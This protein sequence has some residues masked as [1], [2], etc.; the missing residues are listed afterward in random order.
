LRFNPVSLGGACDIFITSVVIKISLPGGI[1]MRKLTTSCRVVLG[2]IF[3]LFSTSYYLHF[4]PI[5]EHPEAAKNFTSAMAATGY[6]YPLLK[7]TEFVCGLALLTGV[8]VP[9]G[10]TLLAPILINIALFHLVL[11]PGGLGFTA[12]LAFLEVFLAWS[13]RDAFRGLVSLHSPHKRS[14]AA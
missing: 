1:T 6:M 4:I 9:L 8:M 13:Y 11:A 12:L 7:G 2:A 14:S 5:P 3:V 10:L